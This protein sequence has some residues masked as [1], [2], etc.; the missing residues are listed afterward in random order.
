VGNGFQPGSPVRLQ[1]FESSSDGPLL[2]ENLTAGV[3]GRIETTLTAP[4]SSEARMFGVEAKGRRTDG[5]LLL[6]EAIL[7]AQDCAAVQR[8]FPPTA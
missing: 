6:M 5:E 1:F 7:I 4:E 3:S 8:A 2:T